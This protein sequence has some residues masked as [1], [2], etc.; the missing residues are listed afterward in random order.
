MQTDWLALI[1]F[2][3]IKFDHFCKKF[4]NPW[5]RSSVNILYKSKLKSSFSKF[6]HDKPLIGLT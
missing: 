6:L 2:H 4:G 3:L 1:H 5:T